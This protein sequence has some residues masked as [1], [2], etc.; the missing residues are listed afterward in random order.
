MSAAKQFMLADSLAA[1]IDLDRAVC[2]FLHVRD[3]SKASQWAGVSQRT[4]GQFGVFY[5]Q[6]CADA[7]G[8]NLPALDTEIVAA[9]VPNWADY[10]PPP[11]QEEP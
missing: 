10:V 4:D 5:A 8:F 3:G 1:A 6:E 2:A 11:P 7:L 9:G